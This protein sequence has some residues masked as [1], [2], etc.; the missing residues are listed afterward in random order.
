MA[1]SGFESFRMIS[2]GAK[3]LLTSEKVRAD[4]HTRA[5]RVKQSADAQLAQLDSP[6]PPVTVGSTTGTNRAGAVVGGVPMPLERSRRI[7]GGAIDAA[8]G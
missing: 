6:Y 5:E 3:A 2:R 4:L 8:G 1:G 7:L